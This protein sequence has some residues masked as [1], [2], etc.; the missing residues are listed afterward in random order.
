MTAPYKIGDKVSPK[1]NYNRCATVCGQ[2]CKSKT[3]KSWLYH[4]FKTAEIIFI[5]ESGNVDV[6]NN[7][8]IWYDI[9]PEML[10]IA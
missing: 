1:A 7:H 2:C 9:L 4:E 5:H 8:G 6:Q 10:E 3:E